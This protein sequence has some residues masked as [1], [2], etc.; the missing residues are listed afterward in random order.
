[1]DFSELDDD[2][3]KAPA[4]SRSKQF[5]V[6]KVGQVGKPNAVRSQLNIE[7][8]IDDTLEN[9]SYRQDFSSPPLRCE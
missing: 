9:S 4:E 8:H 5:K 7:Q 2:D 3:Y 6:V 1:V